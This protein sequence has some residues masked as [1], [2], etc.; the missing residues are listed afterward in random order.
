MASGIAYGGLSIRMAMCST[1]CY[2]AAKKFFRKLL[3]GLT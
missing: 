1:F 2:K 3:K